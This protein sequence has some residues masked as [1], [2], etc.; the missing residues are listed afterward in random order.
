M[1]TIGTYTGKKYRFIN[2]E[3]VFDNRAWREERREVY[4]EKSNFVMT[5]SYKNYLAEKARSERENELRVLRQ[6]LEYQYKTYGYVDEIDLGEF[7][8]KATH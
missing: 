4:T 5:R 6:K 7:M 2:K 8:A 1:N 3:T